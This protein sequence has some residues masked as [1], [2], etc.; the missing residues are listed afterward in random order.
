MP[1]KNTEKLSQPKDFAKNFGH[2]RTVLFASGQLVTEKLVVEELRRVVGDQR[3]PVHSRINAAD[4]MDR[5]RVIVSHY[6]KELTLSEQ[7]EYYIIGLTNIF[8]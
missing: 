2:E 1:G 8:L 4:S 6:P 7:K 3:I 5:S